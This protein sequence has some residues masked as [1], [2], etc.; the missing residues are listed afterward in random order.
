MQIMRMSVI[1]IA[2]LLPWLQAQVP[3]LPE[4]AQTRWEIA[5]TDEI[6]VQLLFDTTSVAKRLPEDF[7]FVTLGD[8]ADNWPT[9]RTYLAT[10]PEQSGY[11]VSILEI[12]RQDHFS[13]D[14]R[15]PRWG[16]SGA[17]AL[18]LA[19]VA[20]IGLKEERT[21]GSEYV[22]L[23]I[24][25]PDR[26]YVEYMNKKGHYAE[27]GQV[28]LR[29][30]KLGVRHGTID[31]TALHVE[32]TCTPRAELSTGGPSYQTIYPPRGTVDS[33]LILAFSGNRDGQCQGSWKISGTNP[34]AKAIVVGTP[35]YACCGQF[36]GGAYKR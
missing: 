9:A 31:T 7:R 22:S 6:A 35:I 23:L 16:A 12:A 27:V 1:T 10:H 24:L 4:G 33:F 18:W 32:A 36:V 28:T 2:L 19:R 26:A 21:R 29:S 25:I 14:G 34:L 17:A 30:D 5:G 3:P 13:I 20:A 11:G 15:E 8:V